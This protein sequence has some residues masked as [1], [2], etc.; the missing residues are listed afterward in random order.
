M[1]KSLALRITPWILFLTGAVALYLGNLGLASERKTEGWIETEGKVIGSSVETRTTDHRM[2]YVPLVLYEFRVGSVIR[3]G[4]RLTVSS[5]VT[6]SQADAQA[7]VN[8]Y[9]IGRAISVYYNPTVASESVLVR[10]SP[11]PSYVLIGCGVLCV[12][13]GPLAA[14]VSSRRRS[15]GRGAES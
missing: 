15:R 14:V 8:A 9:P 2:Q 10:N 6:G 5:Q 12:F 3:H 7:T 1:V 4:S 13:S 11:V